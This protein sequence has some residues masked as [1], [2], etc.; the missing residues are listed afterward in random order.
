MKNLVKI[1]TVP[2]PTYLYKSYK[3]AIHELC[4]GTKFFY[5]VVERRVRTL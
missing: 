2:T 1:R 3:E 5:K 4:Y